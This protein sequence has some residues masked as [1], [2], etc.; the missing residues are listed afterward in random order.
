MSKLVAIVGPTASG[1]SELAMMVARDFGGEIICA[2]SRTIYRGM[3]IGTAKP[4][5][6][7]QHEIKH[8]MLDLVDPKQSYSAAEFKAAAQEAIGEIRARHHLPIVVGGSGLYAYALLYDYEFPD[9]ADN[10]LRQELQQ[11]SIG[12][13]VDRLKTADPEAYETIDL[14]NPRRVI[15]AI[16]TAGITKTK[17]QL[18]DGAILIGINPSADELVGR[19]QQRTKQMMSAGLL[20]ET[21]RLVDSYGAELEALRSPGYAEMLEC[22]SGQISNTEAEDLINLHTR[23]LAKRQMTW[24]RRNPDIKWFETLE[25][26]R[27]YIASQLS[28]QKV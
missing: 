28:E 21:S 3:D 12:G 24:F 7:D 18:M 20:A 13:L 2:D 26:A 19:I 15:R 22:L 4:S 11:L 17:H 9:G 27:A 8:H 16:E 5:Q 1:K 25:A 23:Q 10:Q 14:Q 6:Q